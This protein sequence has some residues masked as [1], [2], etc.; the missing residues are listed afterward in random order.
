MNSSVMVYLL[1]GKS[2][3]SFLKEITLSTSENIAHDVIKVA[4]YFR[5]Y[6]S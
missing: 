6:G 2:D 1:A 5:Y 4:V 3:R